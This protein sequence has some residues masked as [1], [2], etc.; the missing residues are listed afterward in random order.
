MIFALVTLIASLGLAPADAVTLAFDVRDV[1]LEDAPL[2]AGDDARMRTAMLLAVWTVRE[3]AGKADAIGDS[4]AACG[5]MQLHAH[6]RGGVTCAEMA[7][8]RQVGLRAG[9]AWM[10][11]MRDVCGG[12][13]V[14]G[15]RAFA[16]GTCAGS[17][18][19][20]DLVDHRCRLSGAC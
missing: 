7:R 13:V 10:R 18:R 3:S 5:P 9:L 14:R 11:E 2:F 8:D 12:S 6:A 16:S 20:R 15:L 4:G 1:A 19:A 17:M